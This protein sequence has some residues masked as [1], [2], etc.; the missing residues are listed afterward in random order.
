[1][2]IQDDTVQ[3]ISQDFTDKLNTGC[4]G[5]SIFEQYFKL[6][7]PFH[8]NKSK[9]KEAVGVY[10]LIWCYIHQTIVRTVLKEF[11]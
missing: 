8:E 1:M 4:R 5:G 2:Q 7:A 6:T 11:Q 3:M 9:N 10:I